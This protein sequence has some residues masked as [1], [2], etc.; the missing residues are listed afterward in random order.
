LS[1]HLELPAAGS[2]EIVV[3]GRRLRLTSLDKVLWPAT[4][5]TKAQMIEYYAAVADVLLPH[6][7]GRPVTL[8]RFPDGVEGP[9]FA[10]TECRGRPEWVA[11][12]PL[13]LR[14]GEV[15]NFCLLDD[16]PSLV[17]VANLGTIE[18]H[19]Y[20]GGGADGNDAVVAVFD[21][22]PGAGAGLLDAA[23]LAIRLR[24]LL[25]D[26]GL[27]AF[28]KSSGGLGVHVFV[29][30]NVPH[31]YG[32]VRSFC[33]QLAARLPDSGVK[34]DCAQN[35]PR[36]S[37][38]APYSLRA[39]PRPTVSAPLTW[40]ELEAAAATGRREPIS[41]TAEQLPARVEELGDLFRPVLELTQRLP[42]Y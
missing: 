19:P 3:A 39:A 6:V 8:G 21:L 13:R 36:R 17:W 10:Q 14:T 11:T 37:L 38:A 5:F 34:V 30:L 4:G 40:A 28:P 27:A 22:D 2:A 18:L 26:L 9:G 23:R 7:A 29:P 24:D 20:L 33:E 12:K 1:P 35:H 15:R 31:R 25:D 42:G 41:F 16:V 32:V